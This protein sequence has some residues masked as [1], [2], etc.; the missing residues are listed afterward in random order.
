MDFFD[1]KLPHTYILNSTLTYKA[2]KFYAK[3]DYKTDG[4]DAMVVAMVLSDLD[5]K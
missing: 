2:R 3:A 4:L 1:C 5:N